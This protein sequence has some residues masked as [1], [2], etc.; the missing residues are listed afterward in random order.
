MNATQHLQ[1]AGQVVYVSEDYPAGLT[2]FQRLALPRREQCK[3]RPMWRDS[4]TAPSP[5]P[6]PVLRNCYFA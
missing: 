5:R 4:R 6:A 3:L 2:I 1:P